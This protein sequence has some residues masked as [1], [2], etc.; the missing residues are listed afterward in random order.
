MSDEILT[1]GEQLEGGGGFEGG[2]GGGDV[3]AAHSSEVPSSSPSPE[4]LYEVK[5]NGKSLKVGLQELLNGYSRHSD[6]TRRTQEL[7][8]RE[9]GWT[10]RLSQ[11]EK[12]IQETRA[13][14]SDRA[15]LSQILQQ[16]G[17]ANGEDAD[18]L[19]T[20]SQMDQEFQRRLEAWEQQQAQKAQAAQYQAEV[21]SL[22]TS[23]MGEL[24][25]VY[26]KMAE[27]FPMLGKLPL[28]N[29]LRLRVGAHEPQSLADAKALLADEIRMVAKEMGWTPGAPPMGMNRPPSIEPPGGAGI[30]PAEGQKFRSVRDP[31]LKNAV[32]ADIEQMMRASLNS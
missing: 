16:L 5:V 12:A 26:D 25:G 11:Y 28:F 15:R 19:L 22:K 13:L 20:R 14:L 23:Y 32:L 30:M 17:P 31:E 9:R 29:E 8:Q 2:G 27:Q 24:R 21:E 10:N 4:Q 7:S 18:E 1:G 6:Y 3:P